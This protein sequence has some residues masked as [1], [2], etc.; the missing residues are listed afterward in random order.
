MNWEPVIGLEVHV[1]LSTQSKMFCSCPADY[2][3]ASPNTMVCPV[4]LGMPGTL[5]VVNQK[6]IEFVIMTGLALDCTIANYTQ[7]DRKN[8]PYPDLMK[9]YQISQYENPIA[10][11]GS[12][13]INVGSGERTIRITRAH[14]EED[15]AKLQHKNKSSGI[16]HSLIDVNRSGTPLMEIVG[17]PDLRSSEE[18]K[19]YLVRLR[20]IL[21]YLG[22]T[23]GEMDQGNLRCDAN[24]SIRSIGT[25]EYGSKVEIKN[26]NS[27][28]SVSSAIEYEITRQSSL[29]A[30]G[31]KVEQE[32]RGWNDERQVTVSQRSKEHSHDY[33]FF[34][35]PDLPP[36]YISSK[37]VEDIR[38]NLPE[39]PG[40][41]LQRLVNEYGL[42]PY[43]VGLLTNR[44]AT[45]D[46][47]EESLSKCNL[48]G[49]N[50]NRRA[51][52][53]ANWINGEI[54]RFLNQTDVTIEETN[55]TPSGL[56][57]LIDLLDDGTIN[58]AQ[59]KE[60][61][62]GTL[63]T[64]ES[65]AKMVKDQ[66]LTQLRDS[67]AILD[68]IKIV[69]DQHQEAADDFRKGKDTALGFLVGKVM[70]ISKGE[71]NPG[72]VNSLLREQLKESS[73]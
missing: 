35:E 62:I 18:A 68:L 63:E 72:L 41:R 23:S 55:L 54:S 28:K 73:V 2:Q 67:V 65:P 11:M 42:A 39:L 30:N 58:G 16:S 71:A 33:R 52:A 48:S 5:P 45:A 53:T 32:T 38:E 19:E 21:Q 66:G 47:F 9:G 3:D 29:L 10:S 49:G 15:V 22:V 43:D 31:S 50:L 13:T 37:W 20:S 40:K 46:F 64:G 44:K 60:L 24:I 25:T 8:Y 69:L 61:L 51:K 1:Q 12:L 36:I 6:A 56:S 26:M 7:F 57:D 4:C 34:P 17:E 14:L 70:K 27:F 59:A